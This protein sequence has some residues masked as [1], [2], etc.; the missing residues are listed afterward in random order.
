METYLPKGN[1]QMAAI[2]G[3]SNEQVENVCEKVTKGFA[4]P[5]NYNCIGQVVV[6]G[7]KEAVMEVK[8]IA[9]EDDKYIAEMLYKII[10]R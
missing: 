6:S 5:A 10:K 1:W 7:E 9:E 3:L 4:V 8:E 2:M